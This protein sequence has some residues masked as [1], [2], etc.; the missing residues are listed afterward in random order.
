MNGVDLFLLGRTL[1]KIGEDAIPA[2]AD[3]QYQAAERTVLIVAADVAAHPGSSISEI[4][5]RT[6]FPQS[7]VSGSVARLREAGAVRTRTDP[8]D[9]RRQ[10]VHPADQVSE[11]VAEI[12]ATGIDVALAAA[13]G[14][15][16]PG[17]LAEVTAALDTLA[18]RLGPTALTK[19]RRPGGTA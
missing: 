16:D 11:R 6:G 7:A 2:P 17:R 14:T 5:E 1:M 15:D 13:L 4:T 18:R 12:R 19:L 9:R 10:L 3:G 8:A